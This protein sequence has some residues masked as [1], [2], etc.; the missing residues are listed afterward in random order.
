MSFASNL[1]ITSS[2]ILGFLAQGSWNHYFSSRDSKAKR[3]LAMQYT[4]QR[5]QAV[6]KGLGVEIEAHF[7]APNLF[8]KK[9][10][11][12]CNHMSYLDILI[13]SS[14]QPAVFVTSK[15]M[16]KTFFL[17]DIAKIGG[18]FFVDRVNRRKIKDEVQALVGLLNDGF[19]VF[20]FPEGTSTNGQQFLPF[21]KSLFRV[22][23]QTGST[24]LP[25]CL[26]YESIDGEAFSAQNADRVCWYGDMSFA[27][28]FLQLL[29]VKKLKVKVD[30]LN[31]ID[32]KAFADHGLLADE[33]YRQ[34]H[35][36][37]FKQRMQ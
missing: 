27:P 18:S 23:H 24:I 25:V 13:L 36:C 20:L 30:Y 15:E 6:L 17:G 32:S 22:P 26:R 10:F 37:Y 8:D 5:S 3:L 19:N 35:S 14:I 21:K 29:K 34:I 16:E 7:S 12:V 28:H 4:S 11:I 1:L 33:A 9:Y 31:P 2:N